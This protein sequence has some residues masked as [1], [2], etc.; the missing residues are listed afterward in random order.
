MGTRS[1]I[2]LPFTNLR[3]IVLDEEHDN[4]YKQDVSPKYHCRD[5]AMERARHFHAKV[6]LGSATPSLDTYAR[7][8]KGV[9]ELVEL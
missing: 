9:Y 4:S 6:V 1:A 3:L 7:A 5:V 8:K 2:W